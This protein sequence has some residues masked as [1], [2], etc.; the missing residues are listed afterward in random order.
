MN[1]IYDI[2]QIYLSPAYKKTVKN[3]SITRKYFLPHLELVKWILSNIVYSIIYR[4]SIISSSS[5]KEKNWLLVSSVNNRDSLTFLKDGLDNS[6]YVSTGTWAKKNPL[7][8][9]TRLSFHNSLL[10]VYRLP[11]FYLKHVAHYGLQG[12]ITID[13]IAMANG[14]VPACKKLLQKGQPNCLIFANDHNIKMRGLLL[15]AKELKIPTI[16]LQHA[17]VSESFPPLKFDLA[18][19]EGEDSKNKYLNIGKTDT[20][21]ELVGMPKFDGYIQKV[22]RSSKVV[23]VGICTNMLTN[24]SN[25]KELISF[26]HKWFPELNLCYRPHPRDS[27]TFTVS[28]VRMSNSK[29]E[30]I[31]K[32][33]QEIDILIAGETS[34]HLEA[35][36]LNI[37]SI[38]F[39]QLSPEQFQDY[40]G[41]IRNQL[42][43]EASNLEEI[44]DWILAQIQNIDQPRIRAKHYNAVVD[45]EWDGKSSELAL[46]HLQKFLKP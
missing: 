43:K 13:K 17:S 21:I 6:V 16:Y 14:M 27:R 20:R 19:L 15:A 45:T 35:A 42:V 11:F 25:A 40:Y 4:K 5:I 28:N 34:T 39:S 24:L 2:I 29:V 8:E 23:N 44:K 41:Y 10:Y 33:L 1:Q 18:I 32:F 36:L 38:Q 46:T 3:H 26:L 31:F 9:V 22:K 12:L 7:Q 37:P 30:P